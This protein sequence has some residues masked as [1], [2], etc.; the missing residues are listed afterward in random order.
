MFCKKWRLL[1]H[2]QVT[3]LKPCYFS[4]GT[5]DNQSLNKITQN[6]GLAPHSVLYTGIYV[7]QKKKK[8]FQKRADGVTHPLRAMPAHV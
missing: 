7:K 3:G 2:R 5:E 1:F 8:P 4:V 6:R